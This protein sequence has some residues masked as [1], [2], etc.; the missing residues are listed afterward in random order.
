MGAYMY[1]T[2][3]DRERYSKVNYDEE[4]DK[5]FQE[6]RTFDKS[7]LISEYPVFKTHFWRP[8]TVETKYTIYHD[9]NPSKSPYQARYQITGSGSRETIIAYL[10]GIMNGALSQKRD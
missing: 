6:A 9:C 5:I 2:E 3:W 1:L 10:Y 7:L 8:K 4:L